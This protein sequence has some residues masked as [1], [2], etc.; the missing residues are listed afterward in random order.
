VAICGLLLS[1]GFAGFTGV[2]E[3]GKV[4]TKAADEREMKQLITDFGKAVSE[5]RIDAAYAMTDARF[6]EQVTLDRFKRL[7]VELQASPVVGP[8]K[9]IESNGLFSIE[10]DVETDLRMAVGYALVRTEKLP[11]NS[12]MR[13]EIRYRRSGEQWRIFALPDWFPPANPPGGAPNPNAPAGPPTA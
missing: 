2:K 10:T 12:P 11:A 9:S 5:S 8:V 6:Q 7:L 4:R 3:L 13:P 1:V